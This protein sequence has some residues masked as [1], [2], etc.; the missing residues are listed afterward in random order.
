MRHSSVFKIVAEQQAYSP[1]FDNELLVAQVERIGTGHWVKC[2]PICSAVHV[3]PANVRVGQVYEP[4]CHRMVT[5][6]P[7]VYRKWLEAHPEVVGCTTVILRD[8]QPVIIP[9]TDEPPA[10]AKEAA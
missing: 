6:H 1:L 3:L 8:R 10:V 4:P 2:C 5:N 7:T 9:L